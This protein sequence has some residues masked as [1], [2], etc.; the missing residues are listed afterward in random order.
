MCVC[1]YIYIY[2]SD[3]WYNSSG[4]ATNSPNLY[5]VFEILIDKEAL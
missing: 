4:A 3:Q 1:V 2:H 5:L